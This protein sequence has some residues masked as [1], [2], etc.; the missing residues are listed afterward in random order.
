MP[1]G[2]RIVTDLDPGNLRVQVRVNGELRQVLLSPRE[3]NTAALPTRT[4][5]NEHLT[6]THGMGITLG[7]SNQVTAEGLPVLF[8]DPQIYRELPSF[9]VATVDKVAMRPW[10]G[11]TGKL[12]GRVSYRDGRAFSNLDRDIGYFNRDTVVAGTAKAI[13]LA[14]RLARSCSRLCSRWLTMRLRAS[15]WSLRC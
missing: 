8:V 11:E 5:I 13:V 9:L 3:L 15:R 4:F 2:P 7:P 6:F 10:R 14:T 12:F 1:I